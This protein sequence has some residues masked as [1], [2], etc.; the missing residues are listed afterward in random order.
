MSRVLAHRRDAIVAAAAVAQNLRVV[1][2]KDRRER[3]D[4]MAVFADVAG[5]YMRRRLADGIDRVVTT[6]A[7]SCDIGVIEV[8]RQPA[9]GRVA[10]IAGIGAEDMSGVL[11]GGRRAVVAA[12]AVSQHLQMIDAHDRSEG[13]N[14]VTVFA[15]IGCLDMRGR[16]ADLIDR[17]VTT[18][19]IPHDV[20]VIEV[21]G[22]PANGR[23]AVI[24]GLA[25]QDMPGVLADGRHAVVAARARADDLE[26]VHS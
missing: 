1:D 5:C 20:V 2:L 26:V 14:G 18:Y 22:D 25:T 13:H 15:D 16:L 6:H 21:G 12:A 10:V 23:V 11:A 9:I 17:V 8:R 4:G 19:A 24:A 7:V 3:H